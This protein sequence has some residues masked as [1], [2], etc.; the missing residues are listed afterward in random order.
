MPLVTDF[1]GLLSFI[2]PVCKFSIEL[3][4]ASPGLPF[5]PPVMDCIFFIRL[6]IPPPPR[7][8]NAIE[9]SLPNNELRPFICESM[10]S[11]LS[12]CMAV[13]E[14]PILTVVSKA[15]SAPSGA[16]DEVVA[17]DA[18]LAEDCIGAFFLAVPTWSLHEDAC[19][20]QAAR[21]MADSDFACC[22]QLFENCVVVSHLVKV[23]YTL[24]SF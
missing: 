12:F 21:M 4:S 10:L 23:E 9:L 5:L 16:V 3:A 20:R 14:S 15:W 17:G 6:S 18:S 19:N 2:C 8:F 7:L 24:N 11:D 13:A 22:I 1:N